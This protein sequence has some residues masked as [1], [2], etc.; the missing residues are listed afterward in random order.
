MSIKALFDDITHTVQI[1]S[2]VRR[3]CAVCGGGGP[4]LEADVAEWINHYLEHGYRLLHV[5]QQTTDDARGRPW[6]TTIALVGKS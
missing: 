1:S 6:Q 3:S 2:D 4:G 5:G